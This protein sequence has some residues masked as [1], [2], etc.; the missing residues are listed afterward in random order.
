MRLDLWGYTR[1][2]CRAFIGRAA[3]RGW[4]CTELHY[5]G[6]TGST[7]HSGITVCLFISKYSPSSVASLFYL[8]S[9]SSK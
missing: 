9:Y 6:G 7:S 2:H 8:T 4:G 1:L 3:L 5:K